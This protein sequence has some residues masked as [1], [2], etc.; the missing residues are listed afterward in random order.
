MGVFR[1]DGFRFLAA[2]AAGLM[3]APSLALAGLTPKWELGFGAAV[4]SSP[5]YRGSD[6][7]RGYLLPLPYII[8]HGDVLRIN[9]SGVYGRLIESDRMRLDIS[10]DAGVPVDSTRNRARE[11]MPDLDTVLEFGPSL[12]FCI[13]NR[14][15][16]DQVLELRLPLRALFS[17]DFKRLDSHGGLFNPHLTLD[18]KNVFK[19]PTG[20]WSFSVS[21]GPLYATE[22]YHDYYYQVDPTYATPQRPAYD[23]RAGYSG[24]RNVWTLS[25]RYR[26]FWFGAFARYDELHG[27]A[28]E[29]SPLVRKRHS[30]MSGLAVAWVLAQSKDLV[31]VRD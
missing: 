20:G 16:S 12:E 25:R 29:D 14:C 7:S 19:G 8:Y 18:F 6:E 31:D 9:R 21:A 24:W 17:T 1:Q 11:G 30:F 10:F 4:I 2:A 22:R 23:A 13:W 15:G 28:F 27:A 3:A 26:Q 5:D